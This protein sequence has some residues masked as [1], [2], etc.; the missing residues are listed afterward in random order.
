M[1]LEVF[2][3]RNGK[4]ETIGRP[5]IFTEERMTAEIRTSLDDDA[6]G[7]SFQ[8]SLSLFAV[9]GGAGWELVVRQL[10]SSGGGSVSGVGLYPAVTPGKWID[11]R[12]NLSLPGLE[13][14]TYRF[15]LTPGK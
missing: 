4:R 7:K 11:G 1:E 14:V 12:T 15:R 9:R 5:R 3:T 8:N 2:A 10:L 13:Q 6:A